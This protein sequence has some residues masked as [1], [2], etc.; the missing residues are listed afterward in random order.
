MARITV[1]DCLQNVENRFALIHLAAKRVRQLRK[2]AEPLINAKN[3][4]VVIALRE[5]AAGKVYPVTKEAEVQIEEGA[6]G[7]SAESLPEPESKSEKADD[8]A[9][10]TGK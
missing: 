9:N 5:I 10:S 3:K 4:D 2:G 8:E 1:E 6:Q 7:S